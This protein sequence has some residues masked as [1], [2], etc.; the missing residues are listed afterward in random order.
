[1]NTAE[2][3]AAALYVA[4]FVQDA[5]TIMAPFSYGKEFLRLN[6]AALDAYAACST[7]EQVREVSSGLLNVKL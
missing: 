6:A 2:A 4:G 5:M 3:L 1:M 7:A